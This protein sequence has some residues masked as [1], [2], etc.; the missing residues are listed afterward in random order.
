MKAKT[1]I[2]ELSENTK[3]A[4]IFNS[5]PVHKEWVKGDLSVEEKRKILEAMDIATDGPWILGMIEDIRDLR[6]GV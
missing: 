2:G 6:K 1:K 4:I 3:L 5:K